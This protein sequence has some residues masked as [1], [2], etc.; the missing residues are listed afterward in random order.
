MPLPLPNIPHTLAT[1][2]QGVRVVA[3]E[4]TGGFATVVLLTVCVCWG[5]SVCV[6]VR[7]RESVCV[8]ECVSIAFLV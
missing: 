2:N 5:V 8:C 3:G 7:E 4:T 1:V 6:C